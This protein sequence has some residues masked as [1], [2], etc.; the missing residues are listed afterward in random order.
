MKRLLLFLFLLTLIQGAGGRWFGNYE[1][2]REEAV[3]EGKALLV[4]LIAAEDKRGISLIRHIASESGTSRRL[5]RRYVPVIL[6]AG[7]RSNYPIELYYSTV[8]PTLFFMDPAREVPLR[9]MLAGPGIME[10]LRKIL[11]SPI[12]DP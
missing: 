1:Q 5:F 9:P 4:Y 10:E 12:G 2:A 7:S 6:L 11:E 3:K 8:L